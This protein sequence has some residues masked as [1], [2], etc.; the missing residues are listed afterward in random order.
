MKTT[1][2]EIIR[3][4]ISD[5]QIERCSIREDWVICALCRGTGGHSN[6]FGSFSADE[7]NEHDEDFQ[8]S[9]LSGAYD[10]NCDDCDGTGKVLMLDE[11]ELSDEAREYLHGY[12]EDEYETAAMYAAERRA[13]C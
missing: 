11:D 2:A 4:A 7:W 12:L 5:E 6:R 10:E 13:G 1:H 9:Y 3:Q 8:S